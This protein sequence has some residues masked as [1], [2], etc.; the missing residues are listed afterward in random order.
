[1]FN[2]NVIFPSIIIV[3]SALAFAV[4]TQFDKPMYQD[5]SVDAKFF[6]MVIVIVQIVICI[7]LLM[8][9]KYKQSHIDENSPVPKDEPLVSKM[10]LF[11]VAFLLGYALLI[12]VIGYLYASLAAFIFYLLYFK[13]KKPLYYIVAIVFVLAVYYLFGEVFYISLPEGLWS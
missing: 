5:A 8:Q 2:R 11:G 1:M 7:I 4:I 6:P 12:S 3:F 10:S 9:H 13:I